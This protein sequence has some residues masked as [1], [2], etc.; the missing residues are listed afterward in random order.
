MSKRLI[1]TLVATSLAAAACANPVA[2]N[3]R[4]GTRTRVS[5]DESAPSG[6]NM[7]GGGSQSATPGGNAMGAG[8]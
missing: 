5:H 3:Q 8:S 7:M 6:G 4:T 1:L 2:P